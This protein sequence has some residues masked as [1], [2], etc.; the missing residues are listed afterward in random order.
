MC[1]NKIKG[2]N[3][4]NHRIK[5]NGSFGAASVACCK[6]NCKAVVGK[7]NFWKAIASDT[8]SFFSKKNNQ[9]TTF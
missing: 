4:Y 7:I 5:L 6:D 2:E 1:L 3:I 9:I 8:N